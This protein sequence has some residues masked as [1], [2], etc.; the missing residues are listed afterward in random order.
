MP[1]PGTTFVTRLTARASALWLILVFPVSESLGL[2]PEETPTAG[3]GT[4]ASRQSGRSRPVPRHF[5][6]PQFV[7][8]GILVSQACYDTTRDG[9]IDLYEYYEKGKLVRV[10]QDRDSDGRTDWRE[11]YDGTTGWWQ[12]ARIDGEYRFVPRR[13][14]QPISGYSNRPPLGGGR[15]ETLVDGKW[16]GNFTDV[17]EYVR[18]EAPNDA[19][20]VVTE[21]RVYK[22]GLIESSEVVG[23]HFPLYEWTEFRAGVI[24]RRVAGD[25]EGRIWLVETYTDGRLSM[26]EEDRR[27]DGV[28]KWR[29]YYDPKFPH[30]KRYEKLTDGEWSKSFMD[31]WGPCSA[32]GENGYQAW[33]E[34]GYP[35]RTENYTTGKARVLTQRFVYDD[36]FLVLRE[37]DRDQDGTMDFKTVYVS[38]EDYESARFSKLQDGEWVNNFEITGDGYRFEYVDG[39]FYKKE[40]GGDQDGDGNLDYLGIT[41]SQYESCSGRNGKIDKWY[42]NGPDGRRE[43]RDLDGDGEPEILIDYTN[44]TIRHV[45]TPATVPE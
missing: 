27:R 7:F 17:S 4:V 26:A 9:R 20:L 23:K 28:R 43:K 19:P 5:A 1:K 41:I 25:S 16:V 21:T 8:N 12:V 11:Y 33:Y 6:P 30:R 13:Y 36:G 10:E 24:A 14:L 39:R 38:P 22:N 34:D 37:E 15:S 42:Y 18:G 35:L 44:F 45:E 40:S 3:Y 29:T 32:D 31:C 2:R